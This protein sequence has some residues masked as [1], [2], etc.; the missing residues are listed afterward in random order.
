MTATAARACLLRGGCDP[1]YAAE[2]A[3]TDHPSDPSSGS[4]RAAA[5][6]V[7]AERSISED[8]ILAAARDRAVD[9]GAGA[10]TPAVGALLSLL[11]KLSGGKTVVEVGTGAGVSGL[12][13]L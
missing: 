10:V 8:T 6:S 9:I 7:H 4:S 3:S 2:M 5:I 11:A 13:L 12:W 1:T